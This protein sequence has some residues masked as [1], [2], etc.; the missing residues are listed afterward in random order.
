MRYVPQIAYRTAFQPVPVTTYQTSTSINPANGLPMTC[1][2][3]CTSYT[4]QARRVPYTTYRPVYTTVPVTPASSF[5]ALQGQVPAAQGQTPPT[6]LPGYTPS[7]TALAPISYAPPGSACQGCQ[8]GGQLE[9]FQTAPS[10]VPYASPPQTS[11]ATPWEGSAPQTSEP[12]GATPWRAVEEPSVAPPT[13]QTPADV[14]PSLRPNIDFPPLQPIPQTQRYPDDPAGQGQEVG[15][16]ASNFND[17]SQQGSSSR[18][19]PESSHSQS[20]NGTRPMLE[21]PT[22]NRQTGFDRSHYN[23]RAV[24]DLDRE[25]RERPPRK[26][27]GSPDE[28]RDKTAGSPKTRF[29]SVP[30][31]L[32]AGSASCAAESC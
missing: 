1:T 11:E 18:I 10:A 4:Y 21:E 19:P 14:Q 17:S 27:K 32:S 31:V 29:A 24:R 23:S 3:P 6:L 2:R 22:N 28:P 9:Q 7:N 26:L 25:Q 30:L 8:P 15:Y 20:P 12:Y 16:G 5:A 13:T